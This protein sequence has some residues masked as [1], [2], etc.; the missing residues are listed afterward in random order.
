MAQV[1][2]TAGRLCG[3]VRL[4]ISGGPYRVGLCH[5]L[6]CRK[7]HGAVFSAFAVYPADAVTVTGETRSYRDT[8]A[9]CLWL[10]TLATATTARAG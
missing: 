3:A 10:N 6:D 5:C 1:R 9:R 2:P 8:P 4:E 7:H